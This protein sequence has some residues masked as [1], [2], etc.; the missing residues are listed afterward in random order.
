MWYTIQ[1]TNVLLTL[2]LLIL[3]VFL[4]SFFVV[5]L[6]IRRKYAS[7]IAF[8]TPAGPDQPSQLAIVAQ[9]L[10]GMVGSALVSSARGFLMG[11]K[12]IEKRQESAAAADEI[13]A[14]PIG[15]IVNMLP[16]S[17]KKTIIKNPQLLDI[18]MGLLHPSSGPGPSVATGQSSRAKF[19]L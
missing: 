12:S 5:L 16:N 6:Q 11:Q 15:G 1:V 7:I 17:L 18:A 4:A 14:S 3:L 10:S 2:I 8:I 19:S 13:S 9:T